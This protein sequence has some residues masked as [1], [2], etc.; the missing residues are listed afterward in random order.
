MSYVLTNSFRIRSDVMNK[1]VVIAAIAAFVLPIG[2]IVCQG[3]LSGKFNA[4]SETGAKPKGQLI[5]FYS[6]S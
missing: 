5:Y 6:P 2:F 1:G 4:E 3:A